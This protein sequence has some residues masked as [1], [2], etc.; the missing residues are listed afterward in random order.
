MKL[1][2]A[3]RLSL[4]CAAAAVSM[5]ITGCYMMPGSGNGTAK[6]AVAVGAKGIPAN[7]TSVA[8]V[9]TAP[10]MATIST[11]ASVTAGS[12]TVSVPA[13]PARTFTLLLNG[14][15]AT[16][17]G[18]AT[19]DLQP[20]ETTTVNVTPTLGATQIVVPDYSAGRVVQISDMTGT[21]WT[22][23]SASLPYAVAFDSLGRLYVASS[24]SIYQMNDI[25]GPFSTTLPISVQGTITAMAMDLN[26]GLLYY[27]DGTNLY[28]IQVTPS[29]GSPSILSA[30]SSLIAVPPTGLAVDSS[31]FLYL[32]GFSAASGI[33]S[34]V[35]VNPST[36]ATVA[37][38]SSFT[39]PW[40][41]MVK[42]NYVYVSDLGAKTIVRLTTNLQPVDSFPGPT[43]DRFVGP[44][45]FLAILNKP[46]TVIDDS[47]SSTRRIVSFNDMAGGG[48]TTYGS[49][50][51]LF[52]TPGVGQFQFYES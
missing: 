43:S 45:R 41:V 34:L 25:S 50:P 20:G 38:Y 14:P 47:G 51:G 19:V 21:G 46:I 8:L 13:G 12:I 32:T 44:K 22:T 36:F 9:V 37:T 10:G 33:R 3:I 5:V 29:L 30:L 39:D 52:I 15:S 1:N 40:D 26:R 11:T 17:E 4:V 27:V 28:G 7:L 6:V 49:Y 31:G 42:D 35:K 24:L 23:L 2:K 18:V 48:W 16:L